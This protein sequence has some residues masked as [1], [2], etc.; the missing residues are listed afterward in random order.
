MAKAGAVK[1]VAMLLLAVCIGQLMVD[2]SPIQEVAGT[3]L[4]SQPELTKG[5]ETRR[6]DG[7]RRLLQWWGTPFN[8]DE[9]AEVSTSGAAT[10]SSSP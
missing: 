7:G 6:S 10:A 1:M 9:S 8:A 5:A 3:E 4:S 2:A